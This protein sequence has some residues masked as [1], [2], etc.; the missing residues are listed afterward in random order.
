MTTHQPLE[1]PHTFTRFQSSSVLC[2]KAVYQRN[3][4]YGMAI[5][6]LLTLAPAVIAAYWPVPI[7]TGSGGI[8][9]EH[10]S[11]KDTV[12]VVVDIREYVVIPDPDSDVRK[13][14]RHSGRSGIGSNFV[15]E[16]VLMPNTEV[17]EGSGEFGL[18]GDEDAWDADDYGDPLGYGESG[19]DVVFVLDTATYE[20]TDDLSRQPELIFAPTPDYPSLARTLGLEAK[21]L[22]HV[23][24]G[25]DGSVVDVKVVDATTREFCFAEYAMRSAWQTSFLPALRGR[26]PVRCWVT[27]TVEFVMADR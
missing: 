10:D 5:A 3:M 2:M 4:L 15:S 18:G 27:Y 14:S 24:V 20:L 16:V 23:L 19:S 1:Q 8:T 25:I 21:V 9:P 13:R 17:I 6:I 11:K 26:Q 22:L 7:T 12:R